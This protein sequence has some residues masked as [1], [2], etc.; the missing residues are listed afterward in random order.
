MKPAGTPVLRADAVRRIE[1][2]RARVV[3]GAEEP[4]EDP[5]REE[6]AEDPVREEPAEDPVREEPAEDPVRRSPP[7]TRCGRSPPRTRCG[8][9]RRGP[10]ADSDDE[11]GIGDLH[12]TSDT[13]TPRI[14]DCWEIGGRVAEVY[15]WSSGCSAPLRW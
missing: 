3:G 1:R 12:G 6:P 7:R 13:S 14:L 4:A 8:G 10:G 9:A 5:V 2:L 15:W 11:G